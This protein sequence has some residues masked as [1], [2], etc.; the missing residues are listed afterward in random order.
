MTPEL[1]AI[2]QRLEEVERQ[3]AHLAALATEQ[4]DPDRTVVARCFALRDK[5]GRGR[6]TLESTETGPCLGLFDADGDL[7]ACMGVAESTTPKEDEGPYLILYGTSK[8]KIAEVR[9]C[10]DAPGVALFDA[11]GKLRIFLTAK[12]SGSFV[13]LYSPNGKQNVRLELFSSGQASFV[14]QDANGDPRLMLSAEADKGPVI[15][16]LNRDEVS[17]S[18]PTID[19]AEDTPPLT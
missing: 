16:F 5:K 11:N 3:V 1:R 10:Q 13:Y 18:V 2:F 6:A 15:C 19:K 14:M 7:R 8:K 9:G 12:E 4:S 17:W